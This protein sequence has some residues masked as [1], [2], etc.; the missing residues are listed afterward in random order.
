MGN[1]EYFFRTETRGDEERGLLENPKNPGFSW[2]RQRVRNIVAAK[3]TGAAPLRTRGECLRYT[4]IYVDIGS[5]PSNLIHSVR[6]FQFDFDFYIFFCPGK[7]QG[8]RGFE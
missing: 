7:T 4:S 3:D 1:R 5:F 6:K 8:F 2:P